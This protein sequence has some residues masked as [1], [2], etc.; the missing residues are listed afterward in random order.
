M[1]ITASPHSLSSEKVLLVLN[2]FNLLEIKNKYTTHIV[3]KLI[4][5]SINQSINQ[6]VNQSIKGL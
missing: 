1:L 5:Q 6:S 3:Q 2:A 4:I